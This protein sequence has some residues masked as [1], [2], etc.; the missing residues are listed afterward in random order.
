MNPDLPQ[1]VLF[2]VLPPLFIGLAVYVDRKWRPQKS[3]QRL[4]IYLLMAYGLVGSY[5]WAADYLSRQAAARIITEDSVK[6]LQQDA[7]VLTHGKKLF[8]SRCVTCHGAQGEGVVGPNL[9]DEYWIY[10]GSLKDIFRTIRH[11][12]PNTPMT[13]WKHMLTNEEQQAVANYVYSLQGTN[14]P[15]SKPPQGFVYVRTETK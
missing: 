4:T 1:Y 7:A 6:L 11:G 2:V 14:P 10:G 13:A 12:V 15:N 9:T 5:Q 3:W 8:D